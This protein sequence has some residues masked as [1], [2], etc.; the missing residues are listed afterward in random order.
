MAENNILNNPRQRG[1]ITQ[2]TA[3]GRNLVLCF[4]GTTNKFGEEVSVLYAV[5]VNS[6]RLICNPEEGYKCCPFI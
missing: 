4:D 5:N 1:S 2:T 3:T 6:I